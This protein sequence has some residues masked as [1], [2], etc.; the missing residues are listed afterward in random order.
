MGFPWATGRTTTLAV[1]L[2]GS[3]LVAPLSHPRKRVYRLRGERGD[4]GLG[5]PTGKWR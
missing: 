3:S 2:R 5:I 1:A 4:V